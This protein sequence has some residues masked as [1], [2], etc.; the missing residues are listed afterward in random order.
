VAERL[1][2][3]ADRRTLQ[4][5]QGVAHREEMFADLL[6]IRC[7]GQRV[8]R[9]VNRTGDQVLDRDDGEI[10]DPLHHGAG[11]GVERVAGEQLDGTFDEILDGLLGE[12][13]A[14][15]LKRDDWTHTTTSS[16]RTTGHK[17]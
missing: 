7:G 6:E 5:E 12:G 17:R 2:N 11:R 4:A 14:L 3:V 16:V 10:G 1:A 13:T 8:Q 15:T 9:G